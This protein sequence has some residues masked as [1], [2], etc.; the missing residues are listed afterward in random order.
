MPKLEPFRSDPENT[1]RVAAI[2]AFLEAQEDGVTVSW[3]DIE[4]ETGVSMATKIVNGVDGRR[5]VRRALRE[6]GREVEIIHGAGFR[7][8]SPTN[9]LGI[10]GAHLARAARRLKRAAKAGARLDERHG[11]A[12]PRNERNRLTKSNALL[13]TL[14]SQASQ[15]GKLLK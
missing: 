7:L 11:E 9:A 10:Q 5:L 6:P 15:G 4:T 8:S 2:K 1:K 13:A 3:L 14:T 12:M